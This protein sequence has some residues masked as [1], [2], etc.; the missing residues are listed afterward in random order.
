MGGRAQ[1][2]SQIDRWVRLSEEEEKED[3]RAWLPAR[4]H[5][6]CSAARKED[7]HQDRPIGGLLQ[8][9][10]LLQVRDSQELLMLC[11]PRFN[12]QLQA[13]G[14]VLA[15]ASKTQTGI[16]FCSCDLLSADLLCMELL[17]LASQDPLKA[18][19]CI[20]WYGL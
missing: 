12:L 11:P 10:F 5:S 13:G 9:Q 3:L 15:L 7:C 8:R 18:S 1:E 14:L 20:T 4:I 16:H 2:I 17:L 19:S 6:A